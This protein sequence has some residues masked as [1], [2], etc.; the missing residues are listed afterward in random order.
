MPDSASVLVH[1]GELL[2]HFLI[3]KR[4]NS[5][6]IQKR[7]LKEL[8][9]GKLS[10]MKTGFVRKE[11]ES[12]NHELI[13]WLHISV[14]EIYFRSMHAHRDAEIT[15]LLSGSLHV[16]TPEETFDIKT[17]DIMY[18]NPT[19]PHSCKSLSTENPVVLVIQIDPSFC[20]SYFPLMRNLFFEKSD[21]AR[22]IPEEELQKL[23]KLSLNTAIEYFERTSGFELR[24]ISGI[25]LLIDFMLN[26]APYI[27]IPEETYL[28]VSNYERRI[29]RIISYIHEH[30]TEKITLQEIAER[31]GLT[32]SYL[33]HFFKEHLNKSF[34][35]LVNELRFE[36]AV[37]LIRN[38][39]MK[40]L[41][42]SIESGF[43]DIKYM[44]RT[45]LS[46]YG[47]TP[48]EFRNLHKNSRPGDGPRDD[49]KGEYI[50]GR[51]EALEL[52]QHS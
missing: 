42:I 50:F 49:K 43:S 26:H 24:C 17:G 48:R 10:S 41:D 14:T 9:K 21:L 8:P 30:F 16:E 52:L 44:N 38:S 29:L 20:V 46:V 31:E 13:R 28:S 47:I 32:T 18:F 45:F 25:N 27:T 36:R 35:T 19:Q 5:I 11:I 6:Y 34:Q 1:A 33:S 37:F 15:L 4:N 22:T 39:D 2:Y 51:E 40:I 3:I 7:R 12:V 23:R